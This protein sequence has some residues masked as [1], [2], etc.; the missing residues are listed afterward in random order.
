[1]DHPFASA[2]RPFSAVTAGTN[3]IAAGSKSGYEYG[4]PAEA[5]GGVGISIADCLTID[6]ASFHF[7]FLS[8]YHSRLCLYDLTTT[9][10]IHRNEPVLAVTLQSASN[11]EQSLSH[12]WTVKTIQINIH[13]S[14]IPCRTPTDLNHQLKKPNI[15]ILNRTRPLLSINVLD[16]AT[17]TRHLHPMNH[18][19]SEQISMEMDPDSARDTDNNLARSIK[20]G[21]RHY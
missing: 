15:T 21:L 7:L 4:N 18:L 2:V 9:R 14:L 20:K 19:T 16:R 5:G 12:P 3:A 6:F 10:I 11:I 1:M 8:F 13:I 17:M